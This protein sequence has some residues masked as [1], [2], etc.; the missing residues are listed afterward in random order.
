MSAKLREFAKDS[1]CYAAGDWISKLGTL[2]LV[3]I[4]SRIFLPVDY[5]IIDL[6]NTSYMFLLMLT[7]L[8]IDSG[9]QKFFYIREGEERNILI[10]SSMLFR[11]FFSSLVAAAF[12]LLS[13]RISLFA[14]GKPDYYLEICLLAAVLPIEDNYGQQTLLLRLN[15]KAV[16]F[17][18]YNIS[19]VVIQP[20]LTW[21]CVVSLQQHL[22]GVFIAK[23]ATVAIMAALLLI[24]QRGLLTR[25]I[26]FGEAIVLMKFSIPGLPDIVQTNL[27]NL[28]PRY[29][30]LHFST[31]TA[32]GLFGIADRVARTVDMFKVS[33]NRAWNPFAFANAGK[34]DEKYLYE[35]VFKL[36]AGGLLLL[37][38]TLT[39]FASE[40]LSILTPS[41]YHAAAVLVGGLTLYYALRALT[42]VYSTGLYSVNKVAHTS[43]MSGIHLAA[44]VACALFLVPRYGAAGLVL[45]LDAAAILFF[46]CYSLMVKKYF[47]FRFSS[48]R[49]FYM[50][51]PAA[52]G[53]GYVIC[54]TSRAVGNAGIDGNSLFKFV[55]LSIYILAGYYIL[56]T[57]DE[58]S[59]VWS[60]INQ[61][62]KRRGSAPR[63]GVKSGPGEEL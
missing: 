30:L 34:E 8:N 44:F 6:L 15:R 49:L 46:A 40:I 47:A 12:I 28:L 33:F 31:L 7:G 53:A 22:K 37:T 54:Q 55:L 60:R 2:I 45:S 63:R 9:M 38:V 21:L 3:P 62:F 25:K 56:L 26:R 61:F 48:S 18:V 24:H 59:A 32:V 16:A 52:A 23:F 39:F 19:Q 35:K 51:L 29:F 13:R 11:I 57:V 50:F 42:L 10:S 4:L 20:I 43:L 27:V 36:F 17:S 58:R 5:G 1:V 14:F 41:R